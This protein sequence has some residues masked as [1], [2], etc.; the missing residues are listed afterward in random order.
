MK[1]Y[2]KRLLSIAIAYGVVIVLVAVLVQLI[3]HTK[4]GA[5]LPVL[6]HRR[7]RS[8]GES[9]VRLWRYERIRPCTG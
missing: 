7:R 9:L 3:N 6:Q 1:K 5:V 8:A 4:I 2:Q